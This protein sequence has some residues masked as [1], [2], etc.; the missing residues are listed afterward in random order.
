MLMNEWK[1][2]YRKEE[3]KAETSV[4]CKNSS[5]TGN[6]FTWS[7]SWSRVVTVEMVT[8]QQLKGRDHR[9]CR[10]W[11]ADLKSTGE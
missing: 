2:D 9:M 4:M 1:M 10:A 6:G 3:A 5:D 11:A 8:R 7:Q